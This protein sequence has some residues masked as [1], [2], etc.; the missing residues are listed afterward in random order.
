MGPAL[1]VQNAQVFE[2]LGRRRQLV[3]L[4][5][6]GLASAAADAAGGVEQHAEAPGIP[7]EL[8]V[9][10]GM[11]RLAQRRAHSGGSKQAKK[12]SS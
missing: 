6:T 10:G 7:L 12:R 11:S 4:V 8:L 2:R 1:L 3:D 5:A 9:S